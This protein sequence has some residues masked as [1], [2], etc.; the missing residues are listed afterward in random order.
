MS[1][2][3]PTSQHKREIERFKIAVAALRKIANWRS[4]TSGAYMVAVDALAELGIDDIFRCGAC[5]RPEDECSAV[6]C[7]ATIKARES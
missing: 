1:R 7:E 3:K 5:D 2:S 4:H 6:P